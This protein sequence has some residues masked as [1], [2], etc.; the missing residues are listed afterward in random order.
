M[1]KTKDLK[2]IFSNWLSKDP[3]FFTKAVLVVDDH[4]F[5]RK[6]LTVQLKRHLGLSDDQ[7]DEATDGSKAS[8]YFCSL[9]Q[10]FEAE[11]SKLFSIGVGDDQR[12]SHLQGHCYGQEHAWHDGQHSHRE[13]KSAGLRGTDHWLLRR[14]SK[15][16]L[17][18]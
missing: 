7:I 15:E 6:C 1:K 9:Y 12:R 16:H 13:D 5:I 4:S 10:P 11:K 14:G 18:I 8:H 3:S 17:R 2:N